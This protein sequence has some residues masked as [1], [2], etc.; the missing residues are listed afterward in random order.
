MGG[1]LSAGREQ[2]IG[3]RVAVGLGLVAVLIV[4][5]L[6]G[7]AALL[8]LAAA[9]IVACAV[10]AY[11][12]LQRAGFRPATLL[13]LVATAGVM[14]A[15]YWRGE[16]ALPIVGTILV[17]ATMLW[18]L[19]QIVEA[20]PLANVAVTTMTWLW[21]GLFGAYASLLLRANHGRGL[22]L[23]AIIPV[24]VADIVAYFVGR[25][26]G[27][28]RLAPHISPGKTVE[29]LVA[30]AVAA[31]VAGIIVGKEVTPWG[32]IKHGLLL[33]LAVAILAPVGDLFESMIKRDLSIKDS[34][35][36]LPGHGG[37]LD[38]FDSLLV[39]LPAAYYLAIY[40]G[41]VH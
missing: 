30:G 11:G 22:F 25:R 21:V 15:A 7:S 39:V 18:Y 27:R 36:A 20:R 19:G 34:G 29:G 5:S 41:I 10:E 26:I 6:I 2:D 28:R 14:L 32:G 40:L 9:V 8:V 24:L 38:R 37:V 13:G 33:G 1:G 17:V 35:S 3:Q 31:I 16:T 23:G 4:A 12:M